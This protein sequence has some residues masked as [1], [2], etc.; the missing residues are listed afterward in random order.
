[1]SDLWYDRQFKIGEE[2]DFGETFVHYSPPK[3]SLKP[4]SS[5]I[6]HIC[7]EMVSE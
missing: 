5:P 2:M 1:M 7:I 3:S 4:E 6:N